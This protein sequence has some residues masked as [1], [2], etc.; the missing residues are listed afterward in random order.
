MSLGATLEVLLVL[1]A[2]ATAQEVVSAKRDLERFVATV[3]TRRVWTQERVDVGDAPERIFS[4]AVRGC[5]DA[6]VLGTYGRSEHD[7][8]LAGSVAEN[9]VRGAKCPVLTVRESG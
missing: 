3:D 9:V 7:R 8:L 5:A 1:G 2:D 6:I 4:A